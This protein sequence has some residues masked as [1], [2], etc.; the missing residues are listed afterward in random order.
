MS[1]IS[2]GMRLRW[3]T[4][5]N[6]LRLHSFSFKINA[7]TLV[8]LLRARIYAR[9]HHA[10]S[11]STPKIIPAHTEMLQMSVTSVTALIFNVNN[12]NRIVLPSVT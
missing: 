2:I 7:V 12:R 6:T 3:V 9:G 1:L 4:L 5:G 10:H 8:T 11:S